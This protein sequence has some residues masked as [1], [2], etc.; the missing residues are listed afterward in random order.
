MKKFLCNTVLLIVV[1]ILGLLACASC[2]TTLTKKLI[3]AD[4]SKKTED[5]LK[6]YNAD[7][8]AIADINAVGEAK[9]TKFIPFIETL[10]SIEQK[11]ELMQNVYNEIDSAWTMRLNDL[12][13]R[14]TAAA[15]EIKKNVDVANDLHNRLFG[16]EGL[17]KLGLTSAFIG[18]GLTWLRSSQ[19]K[20]QFATNLT[21]ALEKKETELNQKLWKPE[22]V[23]SWTVSDGTAILSKYMSTEKAAEV[24]KEL[25][26]T[27]TTETVT[28][29][30]AVTTA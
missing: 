8:K 20:G 17:I 19:L 9:K 5:F 13:D 18:L 28:Q 14:Y 6:K 21:A 29:T 30:T 11:Q 16:E 15:G 7:A 2:S 23:H 3:P 27:L 12:R 25:A 26:T 22:E 24:A 1:V 4:T 10:D